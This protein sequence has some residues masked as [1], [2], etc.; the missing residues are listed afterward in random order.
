MPTYNFS[1]QSGKTPLK[2]KLLMFLGVLA[3]V[4]LLSMFAVTF[5]AI[6]LLAG[7]VI[8]LINLFQRGGKEFPSPPTMSSIQIR[9]YKAPIKRDND[10]IDI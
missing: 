10:V 9:R 2:T 6:A 1:F 8:F 3:G 4:T 7:A 5:M